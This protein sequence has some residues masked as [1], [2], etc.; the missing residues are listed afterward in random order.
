V[1]PQIPVSGGIPDLEAAFEAPIE[2][3]EEPRDLSPHEFSEADERLRKRLTEDE[4]TELLGQTDREMI[5]DLCHKWYD[6]KA[7]ISFFIARECSRLYG[8]REEVPL[9]GEWG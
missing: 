3:F 2:P 6:G 1:E 7:P 4:R 8:R 5:G 9:D